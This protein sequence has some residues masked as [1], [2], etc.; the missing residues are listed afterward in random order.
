MPKE[1][2]TDCS[3]A[4]YSK[5]PFRRGGVVVGEAISLEFIYALTMD[6]YCPDN[7]SSAD[8]DL[9]DDSSSSVLAFFGGTPVA[10]QKPD[11]L[12]GDGPRTWYKK[13]VSEDAVTV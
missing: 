11:T 5:K 8:L 9:D 2:R 4:V 1:D 3:P 10:D 6:I 7:N 13:S 12:V